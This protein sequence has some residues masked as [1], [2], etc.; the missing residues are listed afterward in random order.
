M[1]L[2][3]STEQFSILQSKLERSGI[4]IGQKQWAT[5]AENRTFYQILDS[6]G[7]SES[8]ST[9]KRAAEPNYA[10]LGLT[11]VAG[12]PT[13]ADIA[14]YREVTNGG[15]LTDEG[16]VTSA[17]FFDNDLITDRYS[18]ATL[19]LLNDL[20]SKYIG[21]GNDF[22]HAFDA[23]Q[24]RCRII[25]LSLGADPSTELHSDTPVEALRRFSPNNPLSS[26]Y[27][28][29]V[30]D[31]AFPKMDNDAGGAF[32]A[33]SAID[34]VKS[35]LVKDISIAFQNAHKTTYCSLCLLPMDSFW[36]WSYCEEHGFPGGRLGSE[37]VVG[38]MDRVSDVFT[39]GLVSDGAV[40]RAGIVLDPTIG[41]AA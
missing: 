4:S 41:L 12:P 11:R 35:A 21:R 14:R 29:L 25:D 5:H 9:G 15:V 10:E 6:M 32:G 18:I 3:L 39:F 36:F 40:K 8:R 34:S 24:A 13:E 27:T 7:L 17:L 33:G 1:L 19:N 16:F 31:L 38:I 28:A 23:R 22:N 20:Y 37:A 30:G 2:K 26:T